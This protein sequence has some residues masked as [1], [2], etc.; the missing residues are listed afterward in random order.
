MGERKNQNALSADE[1]QRFASAVLALKNQVPSRMGLAGRYDDYVR[2]HLDSM[3]STA[4]QPGW[5]HMGPA[6]LPWYRYF[7]YSFERDLQAINAAVTVP[8][9]DWTV[10]S[11]PQASIWDPDLMGG[12]GRDTDARVMTG[13]FAFDNGKWIITVQDPSD[14]SPGPDLRRRFPGVSALPTALQVEAALAEVPYYV[15]PWRA[16]DDL[17]AMQDPARPSFCNRMEG[18]YGPGSIHNRVHLWVGGQLGDILGTMELMSSP[19]DPVFWLHHANIDRLWG[20]WQRRH[21]G[22]GYHPT[23]AGDEIGAPGHN[24]NDSMQLW[25]N[26]TPASVLDPQALDYRYDTDPPRA[27]AA[28]AAALPP[29]AR[30][31]A[32]VSAAHEH[33]MPAAEGGMRMAPGETMFR[34]SAEDLAELPE[35]PREAPAWWQP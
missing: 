1:K 33:A 26:I 18:W 15:A 27:A 31:P 20:E 19:N 25:G 24:L 10:D 28:A 14:A 2:M 17:E 22:E 34:L 3:A 6:F 11:S 9:W 32:P 7:L 4:T 29:R 35:P 21:P 16:F 12:N 23:G 5:A 8:Y 30:R 13:P